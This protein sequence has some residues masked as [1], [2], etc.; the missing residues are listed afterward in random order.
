M[1]CSCWSATSGRS[2]ARS[3]M[4]H[5]SSVRIQSGRDL[6]RQQIAHALQ[7]LADVVDAVGVAEAQVALT[8]G[9]EAG[10][11]D[12]RDAGLF[13][14]TVL[15]RV[16]VEACAG[17]VGEGVEGAAGSAAANAGQRVEALDDDL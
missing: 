2:Y 15:Q 13:Q 14:Q 8:P 12:R 10:T 6:L 3:V 17:D 7:C 4:R 9:A 11:G 1:D 5:R 16:G